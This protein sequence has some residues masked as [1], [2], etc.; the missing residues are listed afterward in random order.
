MS[1][2]DYEKGAYVLSE[3]QKQF[4]NKYAEV[5]RYYFDAHNEPDEFNRIS[6]HEYANDL[7]EKLKDMPL[8]KAEAKELVSMDSKEIAKHIGENKFNGSGVKIYGYLS[9]EL[10]KS[11]LTEKRD[12]RHK[13]LVENQRD[14]D[15]STKFVSSEDWKSRVNKNISVDQKPPAVEISKTEPVISKTESIKEEPAWLKYDH[16][17]ENPKFSKYLKKETPEEF[18][19]KMKVIEDRKAKRELKKLEKSEALA[20]Y[21]EIKNPTFEQMTNSI[22]GKSFD[23]KN[24]TELRDFFNTTKNHETESEYRSLFMTTGEHR[25]LFPEINDDNKFDRASTISL[26]EMLS[27]HEKQYASDDYADGREDVIDANQSFEKAYFEHQFSDAHGLISDEDELLEKFKSRQEVVYADRAK[28]IERLYPEETA[29]IRG[30]SQ[31]L[32]EQPQNAKP[33]L[34]SSNKYHSDMMEVTPFDDGWMKEIKPEKKTQATT[35]KEKF[36]DFVNTIS[37]PKITEDKSLVNENIQKTRQS[38]R[39]KSVSMSM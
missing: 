34:S 15:F 25:R 17:S 38:F 28:E 20:Q 26:R 36:S 11:T 12:L 23:T 29:R 7:A 6:M 4:L 27:T 13:N 33:Q 3:K 18:E 14:F 16:W 35:E 32:Q 8:S 24:Y 1:N 22:E 10:Q 39:S 9:P 31:A 30:E 19:Q 21:Q 2:F 5:Q 37:P